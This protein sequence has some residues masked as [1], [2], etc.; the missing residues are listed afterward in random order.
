MFGA[1]CST[2]LS[3]QITHVVAAKVCSPLILEHLLSIHLF[4][5]TLFPLFKFLL[6]N[7]S[8]NSLVLNY[9]TLAWDCKSRH[10]AETGRYQ[11]RL[12]SMVL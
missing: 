11:D 5:F 3:N 7:K 8:V 12:A 1:R 4:C 9:M 2:E 6:D 10:G